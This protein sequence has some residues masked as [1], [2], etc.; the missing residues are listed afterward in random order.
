M[1]PELLDDALR[2]AQRCSRRAGLNAEDAEDC[3]AQF[4]ERMLTASPPTSNAGAWLRRCA[5]NHIVDY[6]RARGRRLTHE[7][8]WPETISGSGQSVASDFP[9]GAPGADANLLR[10]E[11]WR[12]L[13]AALAQ[14]DPVPQQ[15][16]LRHHLNGDSVDD[17]AAAFDRTPHAVDQTLLRARKRLRT[18]LERQGLT[19][20]ELL[21]YLAVAPVLLWHHPTAAQNDGRSQATKNSP[22]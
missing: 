17:L 5:R 20:A 16:F 9:D 11:F 18:V 6:M 14:L 3:A 12:C 7:C 10:D 4:V 1:E 22:K 13:M 19:E 2:L 15:I 8:R 21:Q